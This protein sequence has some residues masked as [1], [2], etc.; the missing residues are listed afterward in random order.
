MMTE[1]DH[2]KLLYGP[3]TTP[4]LKVGDR[5]FCL[6]RDDEVV[7][8]DWSLG[9]M[10][11]PLCYHV[12]TRACGKGILVD[13]ELGRAIRMESAT[14]I[15]YWWGVSAVTV[16]HW[17]RAIGANK[18]NNPGSRRLI[19]AAVEKASATYQA[20][21]VLRRNEPGRYVSAVTK[22]LADDC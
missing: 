9:R 5:T 12:G 1:K 6:Y 10:P 8:Y 21:R 11:W 14:A 3:Y 4:A 13:E 17:R 18:R 2:V 22:L 16:T 15:A 19:Q 7:I 20:S